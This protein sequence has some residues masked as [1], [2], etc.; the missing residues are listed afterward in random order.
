VIPPFDIEGGATL[1][2]ARA[3]SV[4]GLVAAAG[5]LAYAALLRPPGLAA[6]LRGSLRTA[7]WWS[8]AAALAGA[9]LW[10]GAQ[11]EDMAGALSAGGLWAVLDGTLFGH[12]VAARIGLLALA[13]LALFRRWAIIA[14]GLACAALAL[15]AGH[16]H[17]LAMGGDCLLLASSVLH[18]LGAGLW[19]GGLPG[20]WLV[21]AGAPPDMAQ[22][23]ARRFSVAGIACVAALLATAAFQGTVL[24]ASVPG[25]VGTAYGWVVCV[26][27]ALFAALLALAARNRR[28]LTPRLETAPARAALGRSILAEIALGLAVLTAAGVLTELQPAMHGQKL[29]PFAW[30]PSLDAAREDPDVAREAMLAGAALAASL[31]ML[32]GAALARRRNRAARAVLACA[33][34]LAAGVALP[35][36]SPLL[37]PA[38]PTQFYRSPT[39]FTVASIDQGAALYAARCAACHGAVG[40]GDGTLARTLA[41]PP[42][43]LTAAHLWMHTDGELFWWLT[44]GIEAPRGGLA[45][46][47]FPDL[48]EDDRWALIDFIRARNAGLTLGSAGWATQLQAPDFA[49]A[50]PAGPT[51]LSA[52]RGGIVGLVLGQAGALSVQAASGPCHAEDRSVAAAYAIAAPGAVAV[53][54][55][56]NGWLRAA[57]PAPQVPPAALA[58]P[59]LPPGRVAQD[60][61]ADMKM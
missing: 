17:A 39:G 26:K 6:A 38:V 41:V 52:L 56:A 13:A 50:C 12:L 59:A 28:T 34:C 60:M 16:S 4:A 20:L 8:L 58:T 3:A 10:L 49:L 1:A 15:Q 7:C 25:L 54:V 55:D 45:M 53:L 27:I 48:A 24:V 57:S 19:L 29:W 30:V 33:A 51:T 61:P 23:A 9:L 32:A 44:H 40:R 42:A 18:L 21:V 46:P 14:A 36:L 11:T 37:V 31:A 2:L 47:G 22:A 43:D 35:H 5:G